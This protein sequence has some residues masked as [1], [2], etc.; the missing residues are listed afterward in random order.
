[1]ALTWVLIG[2]E[3]VNFHK[4]ILMQAT[5]DQTDQK[6]VPDVCLVSL[7]DVGDPAAAAGLLSPLP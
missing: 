6:I 1:M 3:F 7:R 5:P 2:L 4:L